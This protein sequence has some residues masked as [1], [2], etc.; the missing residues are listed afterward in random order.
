MTGEPSER[1]Q[2]DA[3][4]AAARAERARHPDAAPERRVDERGH[5]VLPE[6]PEP[7]N[8]AWFDTTD[9]EIE[10]LQQ[11]IGDQREI[12]AA[13]TE[14]SQQAQQQAAQIEGARTQVTA[15]DATREGESTAGQAR[16]AQQNAQ[17]Q[18]DA[19]GGNRSTAQGLGRAGEVLAPVA[20]PARTVNRVV[21][22][23]PQNRF[24]D[25]SGA[26]RSTQQFV[27]NLD[28]LTGQQGAQSQNEQ[29]AQ[30]GVAQ[31]QAQA[32]NAA[33]TRGESRGQAQ[34]LAGQMQADAGTARDVA[35]ETTGVAQTSRAA[36]QSS[37][38]QLAQKRQERRA[39][40]AAMLGWATGHR[41]LRE[42]VALERPSERGPAP[43][44]EAAS[45]APDGGVPDGGA[46]DGGGLDGGVPDGGVPD[47]GVPDGGVP[48]G[49]VPDGS[50]PDDGSLMCEPPAASSEGGYGRGGGAAPAA[51]APASGGGGAGGG[52]GGDRAGGAAATAEDF[53]VTG[54]RAGANEPAHRVS[55]G[56]RP[57]SIVVSSSG[58][59]ASASV[60]PLTDAARR[61]SAGFVQTIHRSRRAAIY[62]SGPGVIA[63]TWLA[64]RGEMLDQRT[65][66][67]SPVPWY[68]YGVR[69]SDGA[70]QPAMSDN[71]GIE[72]PSYSP[73]Y[74][75]LTRLE[76]SESFTTYLVVMVGNDASTILYLG[77]V[78]W[79]INWAGRFNPGL[80][81][82]SGARGGIGAATR[83]SAG[84]AVLSGPAANDG[85]PGGFVGGS[86]DRG[87][88]REGSDGA[89]GDGTR[90]DGARGDGARGDGARDGGDAALGTQPATFAGPT[91]D[92]ASA[93]GG[94]ETPAQAARREALR[95]GAQT[96][97]FAVPGV[98]DLR[99][100]PDPVRR[101]HAIN[102]SY[103]Q[104]DF[105]MSGYLGEPLVSNWFT[106]G[107]HAS[108]EAGTQ[109]RNLQHGLQVLQD[110]LIILADLT[111]F[112]APTTII[113]DARRAITAVQRVLDLID[114]DAM[115]AQAIRLV[116]AKAGIREAELRAIVS[117]A[118]SAFLFPPLLV[119]FVARLAVLVGKLVAAIPSIISALRL[120]YDNMARG[121]REIYENIAPAAR[122]FLSAAAATSDGIVGAMSFAGDTS[123]FVAA[124]F[125]EYVEVR[126]L[127]DAAAEREGPEQAA[128]ITQRRARAHRANLLIGCQEQLVILQP[129]FDTMME[130]LAAMS[131]TMVLNDPNGAHAL[132]GNWGDF[133]TRMGID[134]A[135]APADPRT[136]TPDNLPP[137]L[138][139]ERRR[140]TIASYFEDNLDGTTPTGER[141]HQA[142]PAIAP[143]EGPGGARAAGPVRAPTQ[144]G[145]AIARSAMSSRTPTHVPAEVQTALAGS[146][147][148]ALPDA[149]RHSAALGADVGHARIVNDD[150]AARAAAS[151][152]ARAFTVGDRVFFGHGHGPSTDGGSLLRHE[153]THVAQQRGAAEPASSTSLGFVEHDDAREDAARRHDAGA[154]GSEA[155][156]ARDEAPAVDAAKYITQF[157]RQIVDEST[158]FLGKQRLT[159]GDPLA[160]WAT[161]DTAVASGVAAAL[162]A[163]G[164]A[165]I[166]RV[167]A[168]RV[169]EHLVDKGRKRNDIAMAPESNK[170]AIE[171]WQT[172]DGPAKWFP[173]VA[174]EI[175]SVLVEVLTPSLQRLMPR[176]L[177]ARY[178]HVLRLEHE[179]Q[180]CLSDDETPE[181]SAAEIIPGHPIDVHVIPQL[182]CGNVRM[183]LG[184]YR[185]AHPAEPI[186]DTGE[187]RPVVISFLAP[188]GM[189]FWVRATQPADPTVEEVAKSLY[190]S[191]EHGYLL[192]RAGS[193]FGFTNVHEL[194]PTHKDA[195]VSLGADPANPESPAYPRAKAAAG[196]GVEPVPLDPA[197]ELLAGPLA[198]EA[199]LAQAT[200]KAVGKP[201]T[202]IVQ[203]MRHS[204]DVVDA[205]VAG[206]GKFGL[207]RELAGTRAAIDRRSQELQDADDAT[208]AKWEVQAA[209]QKSILGVAAIG[210]ASMGERLDQATKDVKD[211]KIAQ[212]G[213]NLPDF[214]RTAMR[215]VVA[216]YVDAA[217]VSMLVET[218][219]ERLAAADQAMRLY[220]IEL[221]EGI[222]QGAQKTIDTA[223][224]AKRSYL[225]GA[226]AHA[227]YD[228]GGLQKREQELRVKVAEVKTLILNNPVEGMARLEAL[229][230]EVQ[231]LQVETDMVGNM[232]AL[233]GAFQALKDADGFWAFVVGDS[234]DLHE[235]RMEAARY[236]GAWEVIWSAWKSG[237]ESRRAWA[238][239]RVDELRK[240]EK[241]RT[242]LGRAYDQVKD[243]RIKTAIAQIVGLLV[244]TVITMGAGAV[245][246][247][248]A[249]ALQLG[250]WGTLA[251]VA[252]TEAVV[253]TT[254]YVALF[255]KDPTVGGFAGELAFNF[256][257]FGVLR[258]F[259]MMMEAAKLA[260]PLKA[261]GQHAGAAVILGGSQL[262]REEIVK[263]VKEG[264]HL[265]DEEIKQIAVQGVL[266]YVAMY[267]AGKL[268]APMLQKLEASTAALG[269]KI[270]AANKAAASVK[271]MSEAIEGGKK[272]TPEQALDYIQKERAWLEAKQSAYDEL[273]RVVELEAKNPPK[274]GEGVLEKSGLTREQIDTLRAELGKAVAEVKAAELVLTL[275]QIA[276]NQFTAPRGKAQELA[277]QL[278]GKEVATDPVTGMKTYEITLPE[279]QT[280]RLTEVE[281]PRGTS[282]PVA[283]L[284]AARQAA[285][286]KATP[287]ADG[288]YSAP[289]EQ[290]PEQLAEHQKLGA[291]IESLGEDAAG[292]R[293]Y[294]VRYPDGQVVR[295]VESVTANRPGLDGAPTAAQAEAMRALAAQAAEIQARRDTQLTQLIDGHA[296]DIV[297][298]RAIIGGGQS[299]TMNYA[300][301]KGGKGAPPGADVTSIPS[302][303][304]I[305]PEGSMFAAHGGLRI[306]QSA[307][308]LKSPALTRQPGEFTA[309]HAGRAS[310]QD[311]VSA[312]TM[313]GYETGMVTYKGRV[314]RVEVNPRDGSWPHDTNLRLTLDNGKR[315]YLDHVD[316]AMGLGAPKPLGRPGSKLAGGEEA[317]LL[318]SG[319][320]VHAQEQLALPGGGERVAVIGDGATGAWAVEASLKAGAKKVLWF[321]GGPKAEP[322][323]PEVRAELKKLGLNDTQIDTYYRAYNER[324]APVFKAVQEGRVELVSGMKDAALVESGP[325]TGQVEVATG[326]GPVYV[327]GVISA[328]GSR[329]LLPEGMR[330]GQLAFKMQTVVDN[331]I[332]RVVALEGVD[333]L[334]NPVGIRLVG[335]Q[336]TAEGV[337]AQ[338][339]PVEQAKYDA[340][341]SQ[342]A[343]DVS[344]PKD[345]RGVAGSIYQT[346]LNTSLANQPELARPGRSFVDQVRDGLTSR[347]QDKLAMMLRGKSDDET[348]KKILGEDLEAARDKVRKAAAQGGGSVQ[349]SAAVTG[350]A[351]PADADAVR[352][353]AAAGVSGAGQAL[354]HLDAIQQSFGSHDVRGVT[355][356]VG[357]AAADASAALGAKAYATGNQVAFASSPDLHTAAH[358]A[359]HVVQQ[360]GGVQLKSS[361]DEPG[362]AYEQHADAVADRVVAGESAEALL[363]E[364]GST[365]D[366]EGAVLRDDVRRRFE[367][368]L[369][370][371]LGAVRVHT[372]PRAASA[373]AAIGARA[374]TIGQDIYFGADEYD[375]SGDTLLAHE[376]A[377]TVQQQGS[378][379]PRVQPKLEVA[380]S[381]DSFEQEADRAAEA[382]VRGDRASVSPAAGGDA[383]R[384]FRWQTASGR[385]H[386]EN[387]ISP[388]GFLI[389]GNNIQVERVWYEQQY[390]RH[391]VAENRKILAALA[392]GEMPWINDLSA[393]DLTVAA[394]GIELRMR[395][396]VGSDLAAGPVRNIIMVWVG[397]P[398]GTNTFWDFPAAPRPADAA[399]DSPLPRQATLFVRSSEFQPGDRGRQFSAALMTEIADRLEAAVGASLLPGI[400]DQVIRDGQLLPPGRRPTHLALAIPHSREQ[401]VSIFGEGAWAAY[402]RRSHA[403]GAVASGREQTGGVTVAPGIPQAEVD[404]ARRMLEEIGGSRDESAGG[405]SLRI[406]AALLAVLHEIDTHPRRPEIMAA[407]QARGDGAPRADE[408]MASRLRRIMYAVD[409]REEHARLGIT[410]DGEARDRVFPWPVQ[411]R[412]I[413]HTDLLFSGKKAEFSVDVTSTEQQ[414]LMV[415]V[416]WVHVTWVVRRTASAST[417]AP[418]VDRGH[419]RHRHRI[420]R[421]AHYELSFDE[422]GTYEVN[423]LVDHDD[424]NPNHFT[425]FVE[426]KTEHDRFTELEDRTY[427]SRMWGE[428]DIDSIERSHVFAGTSSLDADNRGTRYEGAMP[429]VCEPGTPQP[430][431][432]LR[433][434]IANVRAF[435]A[436]GRATA[437][438]LRW[439][440]EYL[441]QMEGTQ[442]RID[443]QL[444]NGQSQQLYVQGVYLA[445]S[446]DARSQ[447]LALVALAKR[448]EGDWRITLF[449]TTQAFDSRNSRFSETG[450]TFREA[451]EKTFTELCKSYPRG[452]MSLRLEI[453]DD[454][455]GATGR[456]I[457]FELD[458]DSTWEAVRR[459]VWN[460]VV[461]VV[462]NIA[463]AATAIF[464]PFTAPVIVPTLIA[465][466]AIDTIDNM[467]ALGSRDALT[468][469]DVAIGIG[470]I[471]IDVIPY[472]GQ[473]TKLVKIGSTAYHLFEGLQL[474][475]EAVLMTAQMTEQVQSIRF[476]VMRQTAEVHAQIQA[477]EQTNP[478]D[479]SLP[480]LRTQL[481]ELRQQAVD[482][483]Q[484]TLVQT[485]TQYAVMRASMRVV[486][487]IHARQQHLDAA[488]RSALDS[489]AHSR[490]RQPVHADDLPHLE[491]VMGVRVETTGTR[492]DVTIHYDV[493]A[494]GG[495]TNVRIVIGPE[496][497][498]H[499][500]MQHEPTLRA[501]QRYAG[502]TGSLH[503]LLDR[504]AAYR[505][506]GGHIPPGSR[507]FEAHFEL[508]KLPPII[509]SL[510]AELT[511]HP[512]GSR[513]HAQ[514]ERQ[515]AS[516]E[517]QLDTHA[518]GLDDLAPGLG[519]VAAR[520]GAPDPNATMGHAAAHADASSS[521][522]LGAQAWP[523]PQGRS[524]A[525]HARLVRERGSA[526]V[527]HDGTRPPN[528]NAA[529]EAAFRH[530]DIATQVPDGYH[531]TTDANG[532][533]MVVRDRESGP[534]N[535][536]VSRRYFSPTAVSENGVATHFPLM[537]DDIVRARFVA[538]G[539]AMTTHQHTMSE[540]GR[541]AADHATA[542]RRAAIARRDTADQSLAGISRELG[543]S[544]ES[545]LLSRFQETVDRLR[546]EHAGDQ[547][548]LDKIAE[549]ERQRAV[550]AS[551]RDDVVAASERLGNLMA[552]DYMRSAHPT[553]RLLHGDPSVRGR[554]GEF[555][556]IYFVPGS[557]PARDMII[558]VE[559]KGGSG[560]LGTRHI[561]TSDFQQGTSAYMGDIARAMQMRTEDPDL[562]RALRRMQASDADS[563]PAV[564]YLL[565]EAPL[566]SSGSPRVGRVREFDLSDR[567]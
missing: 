479:P 217:A 55:D 518:R 554:P 283:E 106:F 118:G 122:A 1:Q 517:Q 358:E 365:N 323:P 437:D 67:R 226:E 507:A 285:L 421:P 138:P 193:L 211:L 364:P 204:L 252:G 149:D 228:V 89:R 540:T 41:A 567:R 315:I 416:P 112:G 127:A 54:W 13:A 183:K 401:M 21:Q 119:P 344:V 427:D 249:T 11:R 531:W 140:G 17:V 10:E 46:P 487:G 247:G 190:G 16:V 49:G 132:T 454:T 265:T 478:S 388:D 26:Q 486:H 238:K 405:P 71:P 230:K 390:R 475:G 2:N 102:Q 497:N 235:L 502:V 167:I 202:G 354:P 558:I 471:A 70:R 6:P 151:I 40:W 536:P 309:D 179:R 205:I 546:R 38:Q 357:G 460:P 210:V 244:I 284:S 483:W 241:F 465:Y 316:G 158:A 123:G 474:A 164:I 393:T 488:A 144:G 300:T 136:I 266:M 392:S 33:A 256:A 552:V 156:I 220:P 197:K 43:T 424:F 407:L 83:S 35:T 5:V 330:P 19:G 319:K 322:A 484:T 31:R 28:Q 347:E 374:Y 92:L 208:A 215:K 513:T 356:H 126:R 192:T 429:A 95:R 36:E 72:L 351:A 62:E 494:L 237:N 292:H 391:R 281:I 385:P 355:A 370:A 286:S 516:L 466:N 504:V 73:E 366:G 51:E 275:E 104:I 503:N 148:E 173:D 184:A 87:D 550:L 255:E 59:A 345:S 333:A 170:K 535:Q 150:T 564:R 187:L 4:N 457:G 325:R 415:V 506:G 446:G 293:V 542:D 233:D 379:A 166:R 163:A 254:M 377:H 22:G 303:F 222:L 209:A 515:I 525:D 331:G 69:L 363:D 549:L 42:Q 213:F 452:L 242:F 400:R 279:G 500:L 243:T 450:A 394:E 269:T 100:I 74:G 451:A 422:V 253:F 134:P 305:A 560:S 318:A 501:M 7:G 495:I 207:G 326:G 538:D 117:D 176:Y 418:E 130:E 3:A 155:A 389:R 182:I 229:F 397:L 133:Y 442:R 555:D 280:A 375:P 124:A 86:G 337:R 399:P 472:I 76:G 113:R 523:A 530:G 271:V 142:P 406:D 464:L 188:Q 561:G 533:P 282:A 165:A 288:V 9:R 90:G 566:D 524:D 218:A 48:D 321:G 410:A 417:S 219:R 489:A 522:Q 196:T 29:R 443:E 121:N 360:R 143:I 96:R 146:R 505:R 27:D 214:M 441:E 110:A 455:G 308:E 290:V 496:A 298:E 537:S 361:L 34:Q 103:N 463:G 403:E 449:D 312:L 174:I 301:L 311:F 539:G 436:S 514:I 382:M 129:I 329:P 299:A 378:G 480:G 482:A 260:A 162:A 201:K 485:G 528:W 498:L 101:N 439:A 411:G 277:T 8:T 248:A 381:G 221:M 18:G 342:Q 180:S 304:A 267:G 383:Q 77:N 413:N 481:D 425:I 63:N 545:L 81:T 85:P 438:E 273:A 320:L 203:D 328:I 159:T 563:G 368:S 512:I 154:A 541:P 551:A 60:R 420:E 23:V 160:S 239:T 477:L 274:K 519:Y 509:E 66:I 80:S 30:E 125:A 419:T 373:A 32:T 111:L 39:K 258:K 75:R 37:Q 91:R 264:K 448:E 276:P 467:I 352:A 186:R 490:G 161:N 198:D 462:V 246:T 131:G 216:A 114:Q 50:V 141:I 327:D 398:P 195:L 350:Q 107:Q 414:P 223:L 435:M 447:E 177:A 428:V 105:A 556:F 278:G 225:G 135:R 440:S 508:Q 261:V 493:G 310:A 263:L 426:V 433:Q 128:L 306:G 245:A 534:D 64:T 157:S 61:Y 57:M 371:D 456:F 251:L 423:A 491:R 362:D 520:D 548:A 346:G 68:N 369:G 339:V 314:E 473:A 88:A 240:D 543:L 262:A 108:R 94:P 20:G 338:I 430:G 24:F 343:N 52:G 458:C 84:H 145:A 492:G 336:I 139:P 58:I 99:A 291:R 206:A 98:V 332:E 82:F 408:D 152:D 45:P 169:L 15:R 199:A 191:P 367:R 380:A 409:L 335:A 459:T 171:V 272:L 44:E 189:W 259:S 341:L 137:L 445:R 384:V 453:L 296:G 268:A 432:Q 12:T 295:I 395:F 396:E 521:Q 175:G 348:V 532:T 147:G 93:Y 547:Q 287:I 200:G 53:E 224:K 302:T 499:M 297:V 529:R 470:Q 511:A 412:I 324:N 236:T 65:D 97:T 181:P 404:F 313:T 444:R 294:E 386:Q 431:D 526:T 78:R 232:D 257:L 565:I 510:H 334:G 168:P 562:L 461:Q 468:W 376:V 402:E 185:T 349:R 234:G 115:I 25:P 544:E 553:A 372:G 527:P 557:P 359:A 289:R 231:E 559:A 109:I 307:P 387:V 120:I 178:Q 476:G 153:L 469:E 116:M 47:G 434:Q 250:S 227:S 212:G 317:K 172:N 56:S 270:R 79:S 353:H 14:T 194:L 340:L